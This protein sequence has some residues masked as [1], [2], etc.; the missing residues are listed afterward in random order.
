MDGNHRKLGLYFWLLLRLSDTSGAS[1]KS[2]VPDAYLSHIQ[3][4]AFYC[5]SCYLLPNRRVLDAFNT[6]VRFIKVSSSEMEREVEDGCFDE[7]IIMIDSVKIVK[8]YPF[9]LALAFVLPV[10][11]VDVWNLKIENVKDGLG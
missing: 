5:H 11:Q 6:L 8:N 3:P 1:R 7:V 10:N 4:S 9:D 2:H